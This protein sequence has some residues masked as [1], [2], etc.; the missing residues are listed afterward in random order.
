MTVIPAIFTSVAAVISRRPLDRNSSLRLT[1]FSMLCGSFFL[2]PFAG[3]DIVAQGWKQ[4][5]LAT[6]L[7]LAYSI[8]LAAVVGYAVYFKSIG[9]IR[10][11][12][13]VIYNPLMPPVTVLIAIITLG[14]ASRPYRHSEPS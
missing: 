7:A 12:R 1:S 6:C 10:A 14:E 9:E 3:R 4:V 2:L 8:V 5:S 11:S 13:T